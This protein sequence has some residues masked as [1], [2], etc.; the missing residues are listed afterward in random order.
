MERLRAGLVQ[1]GASLQP[2]WLASLSPPPSTPDQAWA[3]LLNADL[4]HAGAAVLPEDI[5]SPTSQYHGTVLQ[6]PVLLQGTQSR[7]FR[8]PER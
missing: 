1:R 3:A 4:K 5:S 6:G 7:P 2:S 8:R